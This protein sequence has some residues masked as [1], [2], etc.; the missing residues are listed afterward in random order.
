MPQPDRTAELR[1]TARPTHP[2][3]RRRDGDDDPALPARRSGLSR[4]AVRESSA[5]SQRRQRH[6]LPDAA[7]R[8]RRDPSP[9]SRR[10]RRHHRDEH[11]QRAGDL[12]GR[13]RPRRIRLRHQQSGGR[14]C[15]QGVRRV[16]DAGSSALRGRLARTD[17]PHGRRS[18]PTSTTP[19]FAP[20]R[21]T[22]SSTPTT[23]RRAASSTAASTSSCR[24]RPSTRSTSRP[25]SSPSRSTSPTPASGCRSSPRSRSPTPPGRTLSGQTVE[26]SWNSISHAPL[27]AVG[28]NCALGA[29]EMRP[30]IEELA[31][32]APVFITC[33]PNAGLPN[34]LGE[35]DETPESM[36]A[37]LRDFAENNWLNI[38]GGC[39]G[40]TPDSHPRHRRG[41]EGV[42][43]AR[44]AA[45][46]ET[47]AAQRAGGADRPQRRRRRVALHH[48]RRAHQR[49]RLAEVRAA[50]SR[51]AISRRRWQS[52]SSRSTAART[53][54]TSTW[55][56]ACSTPR[57]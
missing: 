14:A 28:I 21:S 23:N 37:L 42:S 44:A 19:R 54:S 24:R 55:T 7:A 53:S 27:L 52:P 40:T 11:V 17:E 56:R 34:A 25:R 39:C 26:A 57:R 8:H 20:C 29:K 49:H 22:S 48:G 41:R 2:H 4:L 6:P 36:S 31:A 51:P 9:V 10:R 35:Y 46:R 16:R 1:R 30:H 38:V 3:S 33:Y 47:S 32:I 50:R 18:R 43:A 12:A 45:G 5:R 15:A 13:L